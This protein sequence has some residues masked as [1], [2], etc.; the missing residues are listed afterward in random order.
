MQLFQTSRL[1]RIGRK[2]SSAGL[3]LTA[4]GLAVAAPAAAQFTGTRIM[5]DAGHGGT[6]PGSLGIDGAA[7]PNEEDFVLDVAWRL[8]ARLQAAGAEVI[9]TRTSDATTSLRRP[10]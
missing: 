10:E 8:Q 5:I 4:L 1:A 2:L 9:L 6:D 3:A 7:Y